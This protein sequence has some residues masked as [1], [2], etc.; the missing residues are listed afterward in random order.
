[1]APLQVQ[2]LPK[3]TSVASPATRLRPVTGL[4]GEPVGAPSMIEAD[5][6]HVPPA[7]PSVTDHGLSAG[8]RPVQEVRPSGDC[9]SCVESKA[10]PFCVRMAQPNSGISSESQ[11]PLALAS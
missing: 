4:V 1:M 5:W 10:L 11:S 3:I 9:V 2:Q 6:C 8:S 7:V